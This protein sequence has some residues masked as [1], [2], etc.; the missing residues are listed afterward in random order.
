M[1]SLAAAIQSAISPKKRYYSD[2]S[3]NSESLPSPKRLHSHDSSSTNPRTTPHGGSAPAKSNPTIQ[4]TG[5]E[6]ILDLDQQFVD[7]TE[8]TAN[9]EAGLAFHDTANEREFSFDAR[10]RLVR[11]QYIHA[12]F[13]Y[14]TIEPGERTFMVLARRCSRGRQRPPKC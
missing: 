11:R 13:L 9:D 12:T 8:V 2:F 14:L 5:L 7:A 10:R 1:A 4:V 6:G 3:G